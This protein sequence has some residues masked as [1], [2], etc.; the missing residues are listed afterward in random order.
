MI[1]EKELKNEAVAMSF[2][3]HKQGKV[4]NEISG[5]RTVLRQQHFLYFYTVLQILYSYIPI[6]SNSSVP[7]S[8]SAV[9]LPD[10]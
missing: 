5:L 1:N 2:L 7:K 9:Q 4:A 6:K 3:M 8:S 10:E